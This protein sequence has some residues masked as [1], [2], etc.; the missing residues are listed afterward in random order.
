MRNWGSIRDVGA[1]QFESRV[2]QVVKRCLFDW[3]VPISR[4][5]YSTTSL[6][7][8]N[9]YMHQ[10][11]LFLPAEDSLIFPFSLFIKNKGNETFV[12]LRYYE[13]LV[14]CVRVRYSA[15]EIKLIFIVTSLKISYDIMFVFLP[16][17][18]YNA[19]CNFRFSYLQTNGCLI[20]LMCRLSGWISVVSRFISINGGA[21]LSQRTGWFY[22]I[23]ESNLNSPS[24]Y[25]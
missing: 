4:F 3:A 15:R 22:L 1:V 13:S 9:L 12:T 17:T 19:F 23:I 7:S 2:L 16:T 6:L 14:H 20:L 25:F 8:P 11:F 10:F 24:V 18:L 5:L 21:L